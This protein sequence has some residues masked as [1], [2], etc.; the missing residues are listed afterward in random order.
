MVAT[1]APERLLRELSDLWVSLAKPAEQENGAGVLRAC[2]MTFIVVAEESEDPMSLGETIA[3]LMPEHPARAIV[4][5][6]RCGESPLSAR[7]FAQCW[8]PF[9]ERRQIC[10]EQIEVT[11]SDSAVADL[12]S[13]VLPLAVPDLP[14]VLWLRGS[15][16]TGTAEFRDL[17]AMAGKVV[18][19]SAVLPD[20]Q[21]AIQRLAGARAVGLPL[22]DLSWTRLTGWRQMLARVFE[23]RGYLARLP[24]LGQARIAFGGERAPVSAWYMAAWIR[25]ALGDAGSHGEVH[26]EADN[27]GPAGQLSRVELLSSAESDLQ[28]DLYSENGRLVVRVNSLSTCAR[29]QP[30]NDYALL[31]EELRVTGHD[32]VFERALSTAA[33]LASQVGGRV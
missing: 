7:V 9:G 31:A 11:A 23:N 19:D 24:R 32:P 27:S 21:A 6:L 18:L 22:A 13:L 30:P 25:N 5:R 26:L 14:V 10:S 17:A 20:S 8:M 15:R 28:V 3:A 4:I 29:L 33:R 16:L 12:P 1:I 2:S